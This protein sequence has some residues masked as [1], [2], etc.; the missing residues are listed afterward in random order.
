ML[1]RI[2]ELLFV[3]LF[4]LAACKETKT[5]NPPAQQL[6]QDRIPELK[7]PLKIKCDDFPGIRD[8]S[9]FPAFVTKE[10]YAA[11]SEYFGKI[12]MSGFTILIKNKSTKQSPVLFTIAANGHTIDS[13]CLFEKT[14][15]IGT[16]S[17]YVPWI[18]ITD[19]LRILRT[20]TQYY[21]L[22]V[23]DSTRTH[24]KEILFL[25]QKTDTVISNDKYK[26]SEAGLIIKQDD[27][28]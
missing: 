26:I 15:Y 23:A 7:L 28:K 20:D 21:S 27:K 5:D 14:C 18:E 24:G 17:Q 8:S 4:L 6:V 16:D 1:K 9:Y 25:K 11:F 12:T 10:D 2:Q 19:E 22:I 3:V 13:L